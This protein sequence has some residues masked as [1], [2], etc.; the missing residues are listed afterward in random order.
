MQQARY[1]VADRYYLEYYKV[2]QWCWT[3]N[4]NG[5]PRLVQRINC[6]ENS[7]WQQPHCKQKARILRDF[8]RAKRFL[9]PSL[10][11]LLASKTCKLLSCPLLH[12]SPCP[13]KP[14][15]IY[16]CIQFMEQ[17][18]TYKLILNIECHRPRN[19]IESKEIKGLWLFWT[20]YICS[21]R[22]AIQIVTTYVL[23]N[24]SISHRHFFPLFFSNVPEFQNR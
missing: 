16:S 19:K 14:I 20:S 9:F 3:C 7:G 12:P 18:L 5:K 8:N 10:A 11:K 22:F 24:S 13:S 15:S 23:T 1:Q 4:L 6:S 17:C 2:K 21:V